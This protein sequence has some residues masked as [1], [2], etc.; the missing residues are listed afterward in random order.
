MYGERAREP[1]IL[2]SSLSSKFFSNLREAKA[3]ALPETQELPPPPS[4]NKLNEIKRRETNAA[5]AL[6]QEQ[7]K[8]MGILNKTSV[9]LKKQNTTSTDD[10]DP[11]TVTTDNVVAYDSRSESE[12]EGISL[13]L[14][15]A[16]EASEV[17][18]PNAADL[19]SECIED[20]KS[21]EEDIKIESRESADA[22]LFEKTVACRKATRY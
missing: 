16:M 4:V 5:V 7:L 18:K 6:M 13:P 3:E 19:Q 15:P 17:P 14:S 21:D 22:D 1:N 10:A 20:I 11:A 12:D 9:R 2:N 8:A